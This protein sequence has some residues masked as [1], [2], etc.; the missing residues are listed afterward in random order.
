M[1]EG[2]GGG[3]TI[4]SLNSPERKDKNS[5]ITTTTGVA[6]GTTRREVEVEGIFLPDTNLTK[7][8]EVAYVLNQDPGRLR[9]RVS[10]LP[11]FNPL[12]V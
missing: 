10:T 6:K 4:K 11:L 3:G 5:T 1:E 9:T 7:V 2:G 12:M 8:S